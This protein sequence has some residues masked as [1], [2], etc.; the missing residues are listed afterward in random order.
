VK[1][2]EAKLKKYKTE[3]ESKSIEVKKSVKNSLKLCDYILSRAVFN[4]AFRE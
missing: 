1:I 4:D 2:L 3:L